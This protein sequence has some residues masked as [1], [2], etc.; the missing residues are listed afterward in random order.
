MKRNVNL[1]PISR[2]HHQMLLLAQLLK[3]DAPYYNGLPSDLAGKAHY[4]LLKFKMLIKPHFEKEEA[5]LL[6]PLRNHDEDIEKLCEEILAEHQEIELVFEQIRQHEIS[7]DILDKLGHLLEQ[8][9]RKEERVFFQLIQ[10][11]ISETKMDEIGK[12]L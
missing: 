3:K 4:A 9:I 7:E 1:I 5:F 12:N 11:R 8:H 10:E 6:P 2:Q